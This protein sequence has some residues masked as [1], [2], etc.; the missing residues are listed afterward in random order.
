MQRVQSMSSRSAQDRPEKTGHSSLLGCGLYTIPEAAKLVGVSQRALRTGVE[1]RTGQQKPVV[2]TD[3]PRIGRTAAVSFTNLMELRFIARF[4]EANVPLREIRSI[5]EEARETLRHPHPFATQ[6]VFRTDGR[7]ILAEIARNNGIKDL[8]DLR[9]RNFEMPEVV[10]DSLREDVVFDPQGEA[11]SWKPRPRIAPN[12]IVHPR[13]SFGR[14]VMKTS[15]IPTE[16][17][18]IAVEAEGSVQAAAEIYDISE[19]QVRE[20]VK[21]ERDLSRA[22]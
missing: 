4:R 6:I 3:V 15:L 11:V 19:A 14:P 8:F 12:V 21:F 13:R 16:A 10:M 7:K 5:M 1:G 20:A 17:L 9:T 22:A 2:Q 18:A